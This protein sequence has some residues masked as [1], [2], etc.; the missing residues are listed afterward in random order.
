MQKEKKKRGCLIPV[1]IVL[2]IFMGAGTF[3][4]KQIKQNPDAYQAKSMLAKELELTSDQESAMLE[5]F[6]SCGI[7][8]ITSANLFQSGEDRTSY[9]LF[10]EETAHYKGAEN[11]IV[12]WVDNTS[13]EIQE[14]YFRDH[15]I[16]LN[17]EVVSPVTAY[18]VNSADRDN[19]RV[20]AQLAVKECL[21]YPDTAKF[22]AISG[23]KFGIEDGIIIVQSSVTA[24]NALG[25]E[26]KNDFQVKFQNGTIVS[27]ILDGTEYIQ[28]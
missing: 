22:P 21:N 12:V 20:S 24:Q 25:A 1:L 3:G 11:A 10:D 17:G 6:Q 8:E 16:Y 26:G 4:I 7:G 19:Y 14:I 15:D 18:Y 9:H 13:K 2:V 27:L 5:I 28:N 23:W